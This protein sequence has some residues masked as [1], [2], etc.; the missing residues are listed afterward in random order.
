MSSPKKSQ[1]SEYL[2]YYCGPNSPNFAFL[3]HG[4]WGIGKTYQV[5][6]YFNSVEKNVSNPDKKH[7]YVSLYGLKSQEEVYTAIET[8]VFPLL[9]NV[10][11]IVNT[12][13]KSEAGQGT[14]NL[15][16][17]GV[18]NIWSNA[19]R[20]KIKDRIIVFDDLERNSMDLDTL[21]GIFNSLLDNNC[22]LILI[23]EEDELAKKTEENDK[24]YDEIKEKIIGHSIMPQADTGQVYDN[25]IAI[26]NDPDDTKNVLKNHKTT[27]L[28][29]FY[30]SDCDSLRIL[31]YLIQNIC[32]LVGVL[33]PEVIKNEGA[34]RELLTEFCS[35]DIEIRCKRLKIDDLKDGT[36][37]DIN[38][39]LSLTEH[40]EHLKDSLIEFQKRY[41]SVKLFNTLL[42]YPVWEK[43]FKYGSFQKDEIMTDLNKSK[44]FIGPEDLE[45]Y[46]IV[47]RFSDYEPS[48]YNKAVKKLNQQI[49]KREF[50]EPDE[51]LFV[52]SLQFMLSDFGVTSKDF[53]TIEKECLE[54]ID[55]IDFVKE[56]TESE[57]IL[58]IATCATGE[59]YF[60]NYKCWGKSDLLINIRDNLTKKLNQALNNKSSEIENNLL[61]L[62]END[63][64][65]FYEK[66]CI[67]S[68]ESGGFR[69]LPVLHLI[70]AEK[71]VEKWLKSPIL[72][73]RKVKSTL[74]QRIEDTKG[75]D[76]FSAEREW[77][78]DVVKELETRMSKESGIRKKQIS[79]N[80]IDPKN[81]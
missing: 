39:L 40:Y 61:N 77:I 28:E 67:N 41:K 47:Y 4:K 58:A 38:K 37:Y 56:Y 6:E 10:T 52:F 25:F 36:M 22:K 11:N 23:S 9:E 75:R 45:S 78:R 81:L 20:S 21:F 24:K 15:I 62:V 60:K 14:V 27:I 73:W 80:I 68:N 31:N 65:A 16:A 74:D 71:F 63:G 55:S 42:S 53:N 19:L 29:I 57:L 50:I 70:D 69:R 51:M 8:K 48:I 43:I 34:M 13:G 64:Y 32:R 79:M 49:N 1:L 76:E 26:L 46:D 59:P 7:I 44:Y 66:L 72:N 2:D 3:V 18:R 30:L 33:E 54:Y 12:V 35:F 17:T 5:K